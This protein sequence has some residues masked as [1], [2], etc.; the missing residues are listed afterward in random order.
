MADAVI[1][2]DARLA[3]RH[4]DVSLTPE[5]LWRAMATAEGIGTRT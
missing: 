5:K 1:D 2:A 4:I 3:V